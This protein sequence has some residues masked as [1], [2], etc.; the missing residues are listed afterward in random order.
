MVRTAS[1]S[2]VVLLL[3]Q[4]LIHVPKIDAAGYQ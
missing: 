1:A 2:S 4:N 3:S